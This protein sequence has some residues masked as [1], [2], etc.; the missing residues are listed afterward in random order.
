MAHTN[1]TTF[2]QFTAGRPAPALAL[3]LRDAL[4]GARDLARDLDAAGAVAL[5][6]DL[7]WL[8]LV[9]AAVELA[10]A[11]RFAPI[12][13][14][15]IFD[16]L[17]DAVD[18][19]RSVAPAGAWLNAVNAAYGD[20]LDAD[21]LYYDAER[22]AL[23]V[24]SASEPG[25]FYVANGACQCR[26]FELGNPCR[27]RC[28][29]RLVYRAL[30]LRALAAEIVAE[31]GLSLASA[32]RSA[33]RQLGELLSYAATVDE[34]AAHS[35]AV[36]LPPVEERRASLVARITRARAALVA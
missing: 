27:H 30:E 4:M 8:M 10:E 17:L 9:G 14:A 19:A 22:H 18:Y 21:V 24:E 12:A 32:R 2:A 29:A 6:R 7:Y 3:E 25:R 34:G 15:D 1:S 5:T 23:R 11:A 13:R 28:A 35:R 36:A 31:H 26:A 16:E 33:A 20:L